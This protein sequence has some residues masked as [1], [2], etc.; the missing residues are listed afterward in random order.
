M[1]YKENQNFTE[2]PQQ[3][4]PPPE[5]KE[6]PRKKR[7]GWRVFWGIFT[8]FSVLGNILLFMALIGTVAI[9]AT[10]QK[11]L[12]T[13]EVIEQGPRMTKIAVI[14]IAGMI[15]AKQAESI[16]RQLKI[17]RKDDNVKALIIRV[18][19]PGGA[20]SASDRIYNEIRQFREQTGKP[21]VAFMQ[22]LAASGGYYTSV[23]CD[24]IVAEPTT[25]TGSIGVIM[26]H[27]VIQQLLEEKLGI[28]PVIIKSGRKKDWP[29]PFQLPT[30]EQKQYLNDK[31]IIPA[32]ERFIS[33]IADARPSLTLDEVR[34]L[35]DGSI[36][37]AE[38]AL[39]EKLI[40]EIGYMDKAIQEVKA[41]AGL[42]DAQVIEYRKPFSF[43]D[44]LSSQ[45]AGF[46]KLNK[47]TLYE[48]STPQ[49]MY[50]WTTD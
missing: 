38:E 21:T 11:G 1:D 22:G 47:A 23:A 33:I 16:Y 43:S 50:L 48:L 8:G 15:D 12:F 37:G 27:F 44:I 5:Q 26:E 29:S 45:K 46:I 3:P 10:G 36:Y 4:A 31:L 19:S 35:A 9:I 40:D 18:N 13:E 49:L 30:E 7:S 20:V 14:G 42:D 25:I 39:N 34:Q 41:L 2:P 28:Q 6:K 17:A 32:Y 24:K